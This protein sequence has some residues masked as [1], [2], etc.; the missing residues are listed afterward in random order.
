MIGGRAPLS[1]APGKTVTL[2]GGVGG[3]SMGRGGV[4]L[5]PLGEGSS[6]A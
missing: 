6:T 1:P 4:R 5:V 2:C 3:C